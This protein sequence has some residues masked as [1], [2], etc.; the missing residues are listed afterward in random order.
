ML[1]SKDKMM[2]EDFGDDF[3]E[4]VDYYDD[5][6]ESEE[7]DSEDEEDGYNRGRKRSLFGWRKKYKSKDK[8]GGSQ[9]SMFWKS[10]KKE[11]PPTPRSEAMVA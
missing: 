6:V 7:E 5:N 4:L 8:V 9:T 2:V 3:G 11:S 10:K 1:S